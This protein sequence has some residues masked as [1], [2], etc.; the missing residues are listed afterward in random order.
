MD[1]GLRQW[2]VSSLMRMTLSVWFGNL[3]LPRVR[4]L[5]RIG[6]APGAARAEGRWQQRPGFL[7]GAAV[8]SHRSRGISLCGACAF[9]RTRPI[10][11]GSSSLSS[12]ATLRRHGRAAQARFQNISKF[13]AALRDN[14]SVFCAT[15]SER[16]GHAH[17]RS[18]LARD[19]SDDSLYRAEIAIYHK[20]VKLLLVHELGLHG[21]D[22]T[23]PAL[24][25][26]GGHC[27]PQRWRLLLKALSSHHRH[28]QRGRQAPCALATCVDEPSYRQT[29]GYSLLLAQV[30]RVEANAWRCLSYVS[31]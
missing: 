17:V 2:S 1:R 3:L 12:S 20:P 16:K 28:T 13:D 31:A 11:A 30:T 9:A 22:L 10:L 7:D 27:L 24:N 15:S 4:G 18:S 14:L 25:G 6:T 5:R 26:R 8:A 19:D 21:R 29:L 23:D